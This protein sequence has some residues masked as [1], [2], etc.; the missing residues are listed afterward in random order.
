MINQMVSLKMVLTRF[1]HREILQGSPKLQISFL[2]LNY[3]SGT[4][5]TATRQCWIQS[6][7]VLQGRQRM[8]P[9]LEL[10]R[11]AGTS[12][13]G[14]PLTGDL[15]CHPIGN[16]SALIGVRIRGQENHHH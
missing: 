3:I 10:K 11:E 6:Y 1:V 16:F 7:H 14:L 8:T 12:S 5:S 9:T 13:A 2:A 15:R 4:K